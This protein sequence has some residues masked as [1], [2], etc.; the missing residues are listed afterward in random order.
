M[1]FSTIHFDGETHSFRIGN[2]NVEVILLSH[3]R[4]FQQYYKCACY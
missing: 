1:C 2:D 4:V 3:T